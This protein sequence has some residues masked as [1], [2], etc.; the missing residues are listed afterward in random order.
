MSYTQFTQ[1]QRYQIYAMFNI[2]YNQTVM[3]K[4]IVNQISTISSELQRISGWRGYR[5]RRDHFLG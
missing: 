3:A 4:V 1:G 2:G 5:L